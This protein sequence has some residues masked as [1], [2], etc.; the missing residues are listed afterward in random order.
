MWVMVATAVSLL[1]LFADL[2]PFDPFGP[3]LGWSPGVLLMVWVS[4]Y[5]LARGRSET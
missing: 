5:L 3:G 2:S 4:V 1:A